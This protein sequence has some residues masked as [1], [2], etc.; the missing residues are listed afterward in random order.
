M[1][2]Q[3][4]L[5]N[6]YC[7][8]GGQ[9]PLAGTSGH[10]NWIGGYFDMISGQVGSWFLRVPRCDA[11]VEKAS[12]CTS[13]PCRTK[14]VGDSGRRNKSVKALKK[15][16]E[17]NT[18]KSASILC[19]HTLCLESLLHTSPNKS[20]KEAPQHQSSRRREGVSSGMEWAVPEGPG[21]LSK[22]GLTP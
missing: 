14:Q 16:K 5:V 12:A 19:H 13:S 2:D 15:R 17:T 3:L 9:A 22:C 7:S 4:P 10:F 18:E 1:V 11:V 21:K 20:N 6:V 8:F